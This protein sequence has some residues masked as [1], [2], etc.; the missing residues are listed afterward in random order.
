MAWQISAAQVYL[1]RAPNAAR[2]AFVGSP[3]SQS[4]AVLRA[5]CSLTCSFVLALW[6]AAA[7]QEYCTTRHAEP[8]EVPPAYRVVPY[9]F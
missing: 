5:S 8:G 6:V 7:G 2:K 4:S 1:R 9:N 3:F